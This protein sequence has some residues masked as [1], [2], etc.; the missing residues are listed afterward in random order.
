M[1][2][3]Y[4]QACELESAVEQ[5]AAA[6]QYDRAAEHAAEY[7]AVQQRDVV[8]GIMQARCSKTLT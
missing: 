5:A 6:E 2:A 1:D 3:L 8:A 4:E 7:K